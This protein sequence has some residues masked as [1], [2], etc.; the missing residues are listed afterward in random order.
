MTLSKFDVKKIGKG[1]LIALAGAALTYLSEQI[2]NV[3]FGASTPM[4]VTG[5]SVLA[6]TLHRLLSDTRSEV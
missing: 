5:F 1:L 3:D 2:P 4:V 6:N